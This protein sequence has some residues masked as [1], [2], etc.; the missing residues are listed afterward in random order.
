MEGLLKVSIIIPVHNAAE[1]IER[2]IDSILSQNYKNIECILIENGSND[3]SDSL[4]ATYAEK[5]KNVV[6][7]SI[8]LKGVSNARNKGLSLATGDIVGFCDAD[9]FLE[10]NA[11]ETVVSE[12]LKNRNVVSVFGGFNIGNID[13][14]KKIVKKYNGLK[15]QEV[16]ILKALQLLIIN[17]AVMGSVWNKYYRRDGLEGISFDCS[18]SFC[19]DMHF[20]A[21]VLDAIGSAKKVKIVSIPLYC[22]MENVESVTHNKNILF[23]NKDELKYIVALKKI[24]ND[25]KLDKKIKNLLKM[26][27]A[28]FSIDTLMSMEIDNIKRENLVRELNKNYIYLVCNFWE[29]NWKWNIKRIYRGARYLYKYKRWQIK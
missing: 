17:D 12:F 8:E 24:E 26:K 25:C 28:C 3:N 2:C 13:A 29:N 15:E 11:I 18:L 6:A 27:I 14:E 22:Y 7:E 23:D 1:T 21:K 9:D 10:M 5:Y 19:E 4:C 16:S 20:N